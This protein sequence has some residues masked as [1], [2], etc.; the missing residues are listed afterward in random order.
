M[1]RVLCVI[2]FQN[3]E[4][5]QTTKHLLILN[6]SSWRQLTKRRQY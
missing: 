3:K 4:E 2:A 1:Q 5:Q 6:I